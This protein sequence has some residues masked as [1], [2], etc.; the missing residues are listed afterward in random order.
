MTDDDR[1]VVERS[2]ARALP[3]YADRHLGTGE[4]VL[5]HARALAVDLAG[6]RLDAA[7]RAAGILF[8]APEYLPGYRDTLGGELGEEVAGL[9]AGVARLHSLRLVTRGVAAQEASSGKSAQAEVLR[10]M[11]LAMVEDIR[12]V[13]VRLASR[14]QTLR[15][16]TKA[17][18]ESQA[19]QRAIA[20]ETLDIY[21]PLA[22]RRGVWQ[23]KWELEDLSLRFLD[24]GTYKQIA[25][26]VDERRGE[27]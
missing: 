3:L 2:W 27:R 26:M 14:T 16:L 13:L 19:T 6:L 10:K 17:P 20:Q 8:A 12:A 4:R 18:P 5:D 15:F 11:L 25:R 21:A 22:N 1:S 7:T 23:L 9:V 24:P